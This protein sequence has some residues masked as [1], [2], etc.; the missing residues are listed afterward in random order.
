MPSTSLSSQAVRKPQENIFPGQ[1]KY[2]L[3]ERL[4]YRVDLSEKIA[5]RIELAGKRTGNRFAEGRA[6]LIRECS[7]PGN[8]WVGEDLE[9]LEGDI[10][11]PDGADVIVFGGY[12]TLYS[13]NHRACPNCS[14]KLRKR[15]RAKAEK[16]MDSHKLMC[17]HDWR[18]VTLTQRKDPSRTLVESIQI[19]QRAW[20]TL[21][22]SEFWKQRVRGGIK[23]VEFT[24]DS[25]GYHVHMHLLVESRWIE[26]ARNC[27][28]PKCRSVKVDKILPDETHSQSRFHCRACACEW[29]EDQH[30]ANNLIDVWEKIISEAQGKTFQDTASVSVRLVRAY[31]KDASRISRKKALFEVLKYVA[32]A[33]DWLNLPDDELV[34]LTTIR[35]WPRMFELFGSLSATSKLIEEKT[36]LDTKNLSVQPH[37]SEET[38]NV[39][40][41]VFKKAESLLDLLEHLTLEQF[42]GIALARIQKVRDFR[43]RQ[44]AALYPTGR[45]SILKDFAYHNHRYIGIFV[46]VD[47]KKGAA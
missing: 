35:R 10:N 21:N 2:S 38:E 39:T 1:E 27:V 36:I 26:V 23:G 32:K 9:K 12:G 42:K 19:L 7:Q 6:F 13:C 18:F 5:Q 46:D 11:S 30:S 29:S 41:P 20:R 4:T 45:F 40:K 3:K 37:P 33:S 16:A 34:A 25:D 44:L 8:S 31:E 24:H 17:G 14:N 15:A 47:F 43:M 22:K 28:N